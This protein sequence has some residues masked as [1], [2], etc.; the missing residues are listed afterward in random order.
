MIDFE[1]L[2]PYKVL[3]KLGQGGMGAV[4]RGEHAK[5]SERVAIKVIAS[6]IAD[7]PR[8]RR[9]FATEIETLKKLNHPNIVRLIGYGEEQGHLFYSMELVDGPSLQQQIRSLKRLPWRDVVRYGI[10]ICGALKHAHDFGVIHRDLKPANLLIAEDQSMKLTDFGIAK[11]W[12]GDDMTAVGAMLGTAD[13]MA[14]EQAG[15]GPITPRTDLYALGNVLYASLVGRPPFAGKDLTRVITSLHTD[16]PPPIDL[17]LPELP[18]ELVTLIHLLLEKG[19]RDRPPTALAVGNR[20]RAILQDDLRLGSLTFDDNRP[21]I[22]SDLPQRVTSSEE[23]LE[24]GTHSS[25]P[26]DQRPTLDATEHPAPGTGSQFAFEETDNSAVQDFPEAATLAPLTHFR[27]VDQEERNRASAPLTADPHGSSP[28]E[29]LLSILLL[30]GLLMLLVT[31]A[32]WM[33]QPPSAESLYNKISEAEDFGDV[34]KAAGSIKQFLARYPDDYRAEEVS[35]L[36]DQIDSD[37]VF[38]R[39]RV[40]A[41]FKGGIEQLEPAEQAFVEAMLLREENPA[42]ARE[43]LEDWLIVF[44]HADH[45]DRSVARLI[46]IV[47]Q[48]IQP[49]KEIN[50]KQTNT[51]SQQLQDWIDGSLE[52]LDA[53]RHQ[54]FLESVIRLYADKAWAEEEIARVKKLLSAAGQG[55]VAPSAPTPAPPPAD[56][57]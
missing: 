52:R 33:M 4:Y 19:P 44:S 43:L 16:P 23:S 10:D 5:T 11:L 28:R 6:Q 20:L 18:M 21:T 46:P 30:I 29:S 41:R 9:R 38:R 13:Y 15:D 48:E 25:L 55:A 53:D 22:D 14:P 3:D 24:L 35:A 45:R 7:Q 17:I 40:R 49:L 51:Q 32:L 47:R 36:A 27:T 57:S 12:L 50:R 26:T 31:A 34:D 42:E 54:E 1:Q 8:F 37:R 56:E 39:L 2:G